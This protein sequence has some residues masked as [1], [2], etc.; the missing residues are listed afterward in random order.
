MKSTRRDHRVKVGVPVFSYMQSQT[1]I[2][3]KGSIKANLSDEM[4]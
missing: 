4:I 3:K 1:E 2:V